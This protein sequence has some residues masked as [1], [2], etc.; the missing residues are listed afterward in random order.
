[1]DYLRD[2]PCDVSGCRNDEIARTL[3]EKLRSAF[4]EKYPGELEG[5]EAE[6]RET[7]KAKA[8]KKTMWDTLKES[9]SADAG[10]FSFGF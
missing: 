5:L 3:H 4:V 7:E 2:N 8:C 1:L 10:G 6:Y 9:A